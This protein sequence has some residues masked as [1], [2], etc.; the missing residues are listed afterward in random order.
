MVKFYRYPP[1]NLTFL[2]DPILDT[3][4]SI[5]LAIN[6]KLSADGIYFVGGTALS[7]DRIINL[8]KNNISFLSIDKG[9]FKKSKSTSHWRFSLNAFQ[10]TRY[11]SC[12]DD[13]LKMFN[14]NLKSWKKIGSYI[15]I[16]APSKETLKFYTGS[17][18]VLQWALDIKNKILNFSDRKVFIRF[19]DNVKKGNDPLEKYLTNCYCVV[20]LQSLGCITSVINGVPVINLA[21]SCLDMLTI[22][23]KIENIETLDY[24]ENRYEWLSCLSY[25]QFSKD[26]FSNGYAINTLK[27]YYQELTVYEI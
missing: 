25:H 27:K 3:I 15:L 23:N 26:E 19:K 14:I 11:F 16:L 20:S 6:E 5:D 18:D 1:S 4:P 21:P 13:R 2:I 7:G 22:S 24:S 12:P 8:K 17:T 9:Y 10:A